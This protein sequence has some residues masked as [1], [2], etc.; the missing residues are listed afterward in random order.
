MRYLDELDNF[1]V[2]VLQALWLIDPWGSERDDLRAREMT[3][4]TIAPWLGENKLPDDF[5]HY[6]RIHDNSPRTM[7]ES[8]QNVRSV[9]GGRTAT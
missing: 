6:L 8:I 1:E 4:W 3:A 9:L 5:M 2:E 7:E